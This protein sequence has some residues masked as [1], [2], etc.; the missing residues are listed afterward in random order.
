MFRFFADKDSILAAATDHLQNALRSAHNKAL[1]A[2]PG[3]ATLQMVLT[4]LVDSTASF[5]RKEPAFRS[6]RWGAGSPLPDIVRAYRLTNDVL[7]GVL[8]ERFPELQRDPLR[9]SLA[10]SATG[11]LI[12]LA[13][14]NNPRGH[15]PTLLA[16]AEMAHTILSQD[17]TSA[18]R[19][20]LLKQ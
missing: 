19:K 5:A 20:R 9:T 3:D 18:T 15:R 12:G 4:V 1:S 6:L 11:H 10:V 16:A 8:L 14:E 2:T 13:F 17:P 7:T